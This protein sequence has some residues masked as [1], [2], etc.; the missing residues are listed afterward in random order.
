MRRK[1][2][3]VAE[4]GRWRPGCFFEQMPRLIRTDSGISG[5]NGTAGVDLGRFQRQT[6]NFGPGLKVPD[7]KVNKKS[8]FS[9][10]IETY[11]A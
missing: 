1:F 10:K 5:C 6:L 9:K 7:E 4:R 3:V 2:P 11:P 8:K